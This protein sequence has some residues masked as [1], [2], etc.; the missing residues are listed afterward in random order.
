VGGYRDSKR[1]NFNACMRTEAQG[2]ALA[3][4]RS[5]TGT[6]ANISANGSLDF[7]TQQLE[8]FLSTCPKC[9]PWRCVN[10]EPSQEGPT[11][12]IG[13]PGCYRSS[14][15]SSLLADNGSDMDNEEEYIRVTKPRLGLD[16]DD[17]AFPFPDQGCSAFALGSATLNNTRQHRL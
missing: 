6:E 17:V 14:S 11:S 9:D 13:K 15:R 4:R 1:T 10:A 16:G 3:N 2:P 12:I 8:R 7:H 5:P